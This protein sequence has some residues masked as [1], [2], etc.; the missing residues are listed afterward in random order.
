[1]R[2]KLADDEGEGCISTFDVTSS[3]RIVSPSFLEEN[4]NED[5]VVDSKWRRNKKRIKLADDEG[6]GCISTFDVT[7]S[8]RIV[9]LSFLEEN[10]NEDAVVDSK[11]KRNKSRS[12]QKIRVPNKYDNTVCDLNKNKKA[13]TQNTV[14]G[15]VGDEQAKVRVSDTK[16]GTGENKRDEGMVENSTGE[17]LCYIPT[18]I[19]E[20]GS[21]VAIFDE[22]LSPDVCFEKAETDTVLLWIKMFDIPLEAWS[23]KGISTLAS[24]LG[25][26][27]TMDDMAAQMCNSC[28]IRKRTEDELAKMREEKRNDNKKL[29]HDFVAGKGDDKQEYMPKPSNNNTT[30]S[31]VHNGTVGEESTMNT[32]NNDT[33]AQASNE[34]SNKYVVLEDL[35]ENV[36]CD[37]DVSQKR[38]GIGCKEKQDEIRN[39]IQNNKL[40]LCAI[41]EARAQANDQ[42]IK[43]YCSFIYAAN[44]GKERQS[45][46]VDLGRQK[47]VTNKHPWVLMGDF[48]VTLSPNKHFVGG[49]NIFIDMYEFQDCVNMI[50]VEDLCNSGLQFT[51]TKSPQNPLAGPLKNMD[52][53]MV[54]GYFLNSFKKAHA[55]FLPY[56]ISDYSP[57][58]LEKV[59][60]NWKDTV[61][62]Y[63]M[64]QLVKKLK[65][66]KKVLN[67]QNWKNG[68]LFDKTALLKDKVKEWQSKID[69]DPH[70][71]AIKEE[72]V[73]LLKE[74]K[75]AISVE[76]KLLLLNREEAADMIVEVTND[77]IKKA[78]FDIANIKA[79]GPDASKYGEKHY[80]FGSISDQL[81]QEILRIIPFQMRK[82]PMKYLGVPLLAKCLGVADCQVLNEKVKAKVGD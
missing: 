68:N 19:A 16:L 1:K 62:G 40:S 71:N 23:T 20:D 46:W 60:E 72:G 29:S 7:S 66:V 39:W 51:W 49:S 80:I 34:S 63:K 70:N 21:D 32:A 2:I 22:E 36:G 74:Y 82:L 31:K 9:S 38:R 55:I 17:T 75:D 76:G 30:K 43:L 15:R 35:G 73:S 54:N 37:I 48:N 53:F 26:P 10:E 3:M 44:H 41:I 33:I 77:E 12:K 8:I 61:C 6:E 14:E 78:I 47:S 52:R 50:E 24:S 13:S 25:E 5:A 64:F 69:R 65:G 81:R 57:T 28:N 79:P 4:E 56:I 59:K 11:W 42:K 58:V 67:D 27:I 18:T 45:L